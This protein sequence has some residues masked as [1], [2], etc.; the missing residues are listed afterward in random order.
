MREAARLRM[1]SSKI[2]LDCV[3]ILVDSL[4]AQRQAAHRPPAAAQGRSPSGHRYEN[5]LSTRKTRVL[6]ELKGLGAW[7]QEMV[8]HDESIRLPAWQRLSLAWREGV[9]ASQ[10]KLAA[11]V[12]SDGEK[13]PPASTSTG[14]PY[15][16]PLLKQRGAKGR[17]W[18][19]SLQAQI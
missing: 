9:Y 1:S 6:Q 13:L 5:Q 2:E 3:W 12:A 19:S 18:M 4:S 14:L 7:L 17:A 16:R 8:R 11:A 15:R 10:G